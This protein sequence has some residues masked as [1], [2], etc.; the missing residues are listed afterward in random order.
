LA[1]GELPNRTREGLIIGSGVEVGILECLR[2]QATSL[3]VVSHLNNLLRIDVLV[4]PV[5]QVN[6][7]GDLAWEIEL[8]VQCAGAVATLH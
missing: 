3:R 5:V 8:R 7:N 4:V 1:V 2:H 6:L